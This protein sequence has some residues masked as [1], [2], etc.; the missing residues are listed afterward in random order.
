MQHSALKFLYKENVF[1]LSGVRVPCAC[2]KEA[3]TA[4]KQKDK[5]KQESRLAIMRPPR[6]TLSSP[7]CGEAVQFPLGSQVVP[8]NIGTF[9][10]AC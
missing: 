7:H 6:H 8:A 1:I 4:I 2:F 5:V 10:F 9:F 3:L